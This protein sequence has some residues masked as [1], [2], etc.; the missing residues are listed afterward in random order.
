VRELAGEAL[1]AGEDGAVGVRERA[2]GRDD[3]GRSELPADIRDDHEPVVVIVDGHDAR[4]GSDLDVERLGVAL[5]VPG[6]L[7][8]GGVAA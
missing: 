1:L 4:V 8:T 5:K 2:A 6:H 3:A 7:V